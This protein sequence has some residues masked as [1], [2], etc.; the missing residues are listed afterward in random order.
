MSPENQTADPVRPDTAR[1]TDETDTR[2]PLVT[3]DRILTEILGERTRHDDQYGQPSH[4]DL[5]PRDIDIVTRREYQFRADTWKSHNA[6]RAEPKVTPGRCGNGH[7]GDG[8]HPHTAWDGLLLEKTYEALAEPHPVRLRASLLYLA[9]TAVAWIEDVDRRMN[10]V[11][12][13]YVPSAKYKR[14]DGADCCPHAVP[15]GP[16]SCPDCW[17]LVKWDVLGGGAA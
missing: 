13:E 7:P 15:V 4:P 8:P 2:N 10:A 5:D 3:T 16:G 11:A 9:T 6:E 12:A 14:S 17:D 1:N